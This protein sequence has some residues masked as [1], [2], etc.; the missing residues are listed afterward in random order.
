MAPRL[1]L[2]SCVEDSGGT[3]GAGS[4]GMRGDAWEEN[5]HGAETS[6]EK[7]EGE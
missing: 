4:V 5:E 7:G 3:C 6:E 1:L 2:S